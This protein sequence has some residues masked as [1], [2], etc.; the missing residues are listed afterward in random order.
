MA[1]TNIKPLSFGKFFFFF[2]LYWNYCSQRG[3]TLSDLDVFIKTS[4]VYAILRREWE[5]NNWSIGELSVV[6]FLFKIL[7]LILSFLLTTNLLI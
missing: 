2:Q 7:Y 3:I 5:K 1:L 6:K 4:F